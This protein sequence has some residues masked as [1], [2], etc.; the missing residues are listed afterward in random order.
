MGTFDSR[1]S[2]DDNGKTDWEGDAAAIAIQTV[3]DG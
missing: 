2:G 1:A 3:V